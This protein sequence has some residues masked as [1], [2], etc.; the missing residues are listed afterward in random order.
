MDLRNLELFLHLADSLHF[1]KSADAMA[2][3][4]STLSRAIQRLE[5]ETGC[6]LFERDNRSVRLTPA[7]EKLREFGGGLL[8]EWRQLKQELKRSDEP[9]QGRLRVFCSVTASYFLLPEVLERFRR[10]YPQLEI[11]LETGDPA[12]A[13]DKILADEADLAIAARPDALPAKLEFASLQQ[14]P[15]VFIAPRNAPQLNQ[16]FRQGE[17]DWEQLP[18]ILSEQGLARKRSDQWFRNKGIA[19]NIYAEVAGNEGIVAMVALGCGVGLVPAAVIDHS[20]L[21]DKVRII[22]LKPAFKPFDVGIGVLKKRLE[23]PLIRAFWDTAQNQNS[24]R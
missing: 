21:G 10:R 15:L 3:S 14:V 13:V 7:G 16:W 17:P 23:E 1:G 8:Q 5:Q 6:V 19:P 24:L 22:D 12:L 2:V 11:K 18:V 20:P 4:P 9:L